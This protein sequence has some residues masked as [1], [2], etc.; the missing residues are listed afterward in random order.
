M[1][2]KIIINNSYYNKFIMKMLPLRSHVLQS[3]PLTLDG[4]A[5]YY[6]QISTPIRY[7]FTYL[8]INLILMKLK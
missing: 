3:S 4:Q 1:Y 8:I 6:S 7:S 2:Y 5:M